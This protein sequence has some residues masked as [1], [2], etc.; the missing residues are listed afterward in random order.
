MTN[1]EFPELVLNGQLIKKEET[2]AS[3]SKV[4]F[5][6]GDGNSIET[7]NDSENDQTNYFTRGVHDSQYNSSF[8]SRLSTVIRRSLRLPPK[9]NLST[10]NRSSS[11]RFK[12]Q[13][14]VIEE[15]GQHFTEFS[16]LR[17]LPCAPGYGTLEE[18]QYYLR[19]NRITQLKNM[20]LGIYWAFSG[21]MSDM[22][23][24]KKFRKHCFFN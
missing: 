22:I 19:L 20:M 16:D 2:F 15:K 14:S 18:L 5:G 4:H 10:G 8:G 24:D 12:Q 23:H 9:R 3:P 21:E 11:S 13:L 7:Q 17:K 1:V 6:G